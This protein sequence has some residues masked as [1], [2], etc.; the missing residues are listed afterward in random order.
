MISDPYVDVLNEEGYIGSLTS[1]IPKYI[2]A[3]SIPSPI[4]QWRLHIL[5]L[6]SRP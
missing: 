5:I 2:M 1:S 6:V 3:Y 4:L